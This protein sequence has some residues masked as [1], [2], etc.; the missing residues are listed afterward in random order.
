MALIRAINAAVS[1]LR[2][3]QFKID[4]VGDNLANSTTTGFKAAR[5]D[6][7]TMLAQNLSFGTGPQGNLGGINPVQIGL[8]TSVAGITRDFRQGELEVT[9]RASDLAIEGSG[10]FILKDATG[11][12]VFTRDGS[13][14][15][16]P[17]NFL[18]NPS[19]GFIVQGVNADYN[20]FTIPVGSALGDI[21]IPVGELQVA[22]ATT[23]ASFDGN[24]NG[25]GQQA[26]EA[27]IIESQ[28]MK[29]NTGGI[30]TGATLLTDLFVQPETGGSDID[31][32]ID[33]ND[34]ITI[35]A[36]KGGV[37]LPQQRFIVSSVAVPGFDAFGT[38]LSQLVNFIQRASGVNPGAT[39]KLVSATRTSGAATGFVTDGSGNIIGVTATGTNLTSVVAGDIIRFNTG[40]GAG[41]I[42][43]V[44][45]VVGSTVNLTAA[46][47]STIPQPVVGDQFTVHE[48]PRVVLQASGRIR[49]AGNVG[50]ANEISDVSVVTSDGITMSTWFTRKNANGESVTSNAT[51]FDS[52]GNPHLVQLTFALETKNGTNTST[53]SSGNTFRFFAESNDNKLT[54]GSGTSR[55]VG[56]G[57]I[58]FSTAGQFLSQSPQNAVNINIQNQGAATPLTITPSFSPLTGFANQGSEVFLFSQN[59]LAAGVLNDFSVGADGVV[60]GIFSNGLT[61]SLA[62]IHIARFNNPDGLRMIGNNNY[63]PEANS[64]QAVI[65]TPGTVGLGQVRSGVLEASNVDLAKEFTNLIISQRAF[66][67]SARVIGASNDV[68]DELVRIL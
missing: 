12:Q 20:T 16:N 68:L 59:G 30:A 50:L 45:S 26:L 27:T 32:N 43:T 41:Q 52:I 6:F 39:D 15:I 25:G 61:R 1:G 62:Q 22:A 37:Q 54:T 10:F 53:T 24:L 8:G 17:A 63:V 23:Q 2:S 58:T 19:N 66:Q 46:L 42:A 44:S 35:N 31:L 18:H 29:N 36:K 67:A 64:G 21:K 28:I 34:V 47:P 65:G 5:V 51:F 55:V 4:T 11:S 33:T 57:T 49:V 9:G 56:T 14:S 3:N 48:P 60:T 7:E 40:A 13:F 38:N